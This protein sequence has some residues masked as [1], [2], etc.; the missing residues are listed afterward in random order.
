MRIILEDA[1]LGGNHLYYRG[2][3]ED[4]HHVAERLNPDV[5]I[6]DD[7]RSI[8]GSCHWVITHVTPVLKDRI[9]SI[10]VPEF[11]GIDHLPNKLKELL[12]YRSKP[13]DVS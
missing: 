8:G 1:G 10:V 3:D 9:T 12:N 5:L 13:T 2:R 11:G 4:Y 7:C 6:E